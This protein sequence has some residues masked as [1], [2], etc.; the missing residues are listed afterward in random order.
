M[1]D[2]TRT[3]LEALVKFRTGN[4]ENLDTQITNVVQFAYNELTTS[5]RIPETE[6][7]ASVALV[8][9]QSLYTLPSDLFSIVALRS[10]EDAKPLQ[11]ISIR[12][13]D[14]QGSVTAGEPK[15]Y[16]WWR[17]E[18]VI[19]PPNNSTTRTMRLRYI[20][21]VAALTTAGLSSALPREWDEVIVQGAI[22]RLFEW[23]GLRTEGQV[24]KQEYTQ[25][26][27]RR[28]NR[29]TESAFDYEDSAQPQLVDRTEDV[30]GFE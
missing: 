17:N 29:I 23:L 14:R 3:Q 18:L 24:A 19:T 27:G 30:G 6:E 8:Q 7:L 13:Y 11:R 26:I 25:M 21:R 4:R 9:N 20:K 22:F 1:G 10:I 12:D 15:F 28:L 5:I 16:A 2:L